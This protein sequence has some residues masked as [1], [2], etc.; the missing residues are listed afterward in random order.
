[1]SKVLFF[2]PLVQAFNKKEI[3]IKGVN[4]IIEILRNID[5]SGIIIDKDNIKPGYIILVNGVDW[6]I[7]GNAVSD[8][9]V[10]QIIPV[11]HGG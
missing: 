3:E 11:N 2:G 8:N 4:S 7:R 10:I 1:M 9:D 6:R 5:K